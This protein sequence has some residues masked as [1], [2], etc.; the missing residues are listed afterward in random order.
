[1][2]TPLA[3]GPDPADGRLRDSALTV[4]RTWAAPDGDQAALRAEFLT[5]L[6]SSADGM[7]RAS[8]PAHLTASG[9]AVDAEGR[10][11]ALVLHRKVGRWLQPGGHCEAG[12]ATLA[13]AARREV[14]EET[15]LVGLTPVGE[16]PVD[17][18]RH[19]APCRPGR[20]D[21]HFDVRFLFRAPAGATLQVSEES[22]DVQ[23]FPLTELATDA[24]ESIARLA[25]RALAH[26]SRR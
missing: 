15:G 10:S 24:D 22:A 18:D 3:S 17:L 14:S 13:D 16:G 2:T 11:A 6:E 4:L 1:M 8:S 26:M 20:G 5:Y 7:W 23:W 9:L 25:R 12:D 19:P 21:Q